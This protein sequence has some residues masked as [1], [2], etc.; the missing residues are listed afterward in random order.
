MVLNGRPLGAAD[1]PAPLHG[2]GTPE[3]APLS[4]SR[5]PV[6]VTT[7]PS[8]LGGYAIG[9]NPHHVPVSLHQTP[10]HSPTPAIAPGDSRPRPPVTHCHTCRWSG[11]PITPRRHYAMSETQLLR[12]LAPLPG[13]SQTGVQLAI[14]LALTGTLTSRF[15]RGTQV[16]PHLR[17]LAG[18]APIGESWQPGTGLAS[19]RPTGNANGVQ[20]P[21]HEGVRPPARASRRGHRAS[22][23]PK[24]HITR[25]RRNPRC[26]TSPGGNPDE[27]S[28]SRGE[29]DHF[30]HRPSP[31]RPEEASR[32]HPSSVGL[33]QPRTA[34]GADNT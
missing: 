15:S 1:L 16:T 31:R 28:V 5:A 6:H 25:Q 18:V 2:A 20:R 33:K 21:N 9:R 32:R 34:C 8:S 26:P 27:G 24:S 7:K 4:A 22:P 12:F 29:H 10:T 13:S 3:A 14:T 23:G 17:N 30:F 11:D 19:T